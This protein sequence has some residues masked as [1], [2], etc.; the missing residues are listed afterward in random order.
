MKQIS[1][2]GIVLSRTN[3]GEADRILTVLTTDSGKVRLMARG[4][5]KIKS[6]LAGGIELFSV[7]QISFVLGKGEIHTL[8]SSRL[9]QHFGSIVN[10]VERTMFAYETLKIV[11]RATE[12]EPGGEYFDML[13]KVLEATDDR[14]IPL[15]LIRLWLYLQLLKY[16]GHSPNLT[17]D[18]EKNSLL[19]DQKYTFDIDHMAFAQKNNG[20]Y[21]SEHIKL[22]RLALGLNSPIQLMKIKD[23]NKVLGACLALVIIMAEQHLR[24]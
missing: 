8:T 22:L 20:P 15:D 11:N 24:I 7:S 21:N 9:K 13:Q 19:P 4:V 5:R 10:D 16:G 6:K 3:F 12:D 14:N 2:L 17:K 18:H 23:I 1:T